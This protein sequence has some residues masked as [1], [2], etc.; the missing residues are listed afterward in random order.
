MEINEM[1][2]VSVDDHVVEPP[3]LFE[4][5]L[6]AKY[7]DLAPKFITNEDGTNAWLYEG[8]VLAQRGPQRGGRPAPRGV[9][10]RAHLV[11]SAPPGLLRHRRAGEGHGRQ[12]RARLALLPLL[13][14]VLRPA[15]RPH[16]GQ[17]RR[18]GHG[19]GLQ[20]LAHRRVVRDPP[21]SVHPL[22]AAGHL[23][24]RSAGRRGTPNGGQGRPRG[25]LLGE[26]LQAGLAQ[27]PLRLLGPVLAGL[28]RGGGR[29]VHAHRLVLGARDH[30]ARRPHRLPDH[31]DPDE[32]RPGRR[33]PGVVAGAPQVPRPE[34]GA[35]RGRD[36]LDSLLPRAD[37]L[38]LR[39]P[40]RS[41]P[42][43][44]SATR[45]PARSSTG[46]C[47]PASSTTGSGSPAATSS[48]WTT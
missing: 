12:R 24:S 25:D 18:P 30:L 42:A 4:G 16:R 40:S 9:R 23:G 36:R 45:C 19:P 48:T 34:G 46:T 38:Q 20:R 35:V 2:M 37:R 8:Q 43:R 13:P 1:V 17:G 39:P 28:Q 22:P 33:R 44:T 31:P 11:R 27:H 29:G 26:P 14:P 3:H 32:H 7:V 6:P 41:G 47:S 10:H 5:R 15:L 21:G